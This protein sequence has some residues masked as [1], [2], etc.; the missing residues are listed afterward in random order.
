MTSSEGAARQ[1]AEDLLIRSGAALSTGGF[2]SF[3]D[4]F[5]LPQTIA[6]FEGKRVVET[7]QELRDLFNR[8]RDHLEKLNISDLVCT[9]T[10]A[11]FRDADTII[12]SHTSRLLSGTDLVEEPYHVLYVIRRTEGGWRIAQAQY[13]LPGDGSHAAAILGA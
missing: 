7:L 3:A 2:D 13:A 6:T 5:S 9:C 1:I 10:A 11:E 4:C 12:S 8:V